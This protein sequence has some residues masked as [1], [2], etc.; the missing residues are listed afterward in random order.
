MTDGRVGKK[1]KRDNASREDRRLTDRAEGEMMTLR[2]KGRRLFP[3]SLDGG[4]S[5]SSPFFFES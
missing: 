3:E 4:S 1:T 5:L 2:H